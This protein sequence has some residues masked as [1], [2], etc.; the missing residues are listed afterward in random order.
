MGADGKHHKLIVYQNR[1]NIIFA[2]NKPNTRMPILGN[3]FKSANS[4]RETT[5]PRATSSEKTVREKKN[6]LPNISLA[7][8]RVVKITGLFF[9]IISLYFMVAF[10]SYLFTWQDDQSYVLASNGGWSNLF[11]TQKDFL[12]MGIK[13]PVVQNWLGKLGGLLAHQFIYEWFGIASF[14]FIAIFFI[15]GYRLLFKVKIW[16]IQKSLGYCFFLLIFIS[17]FIDVFDS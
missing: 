15:V 9:L 4:F 1:Y 14:I 17:V 6:I 13:Q 16:S 8:R 7:D 11:K 10:T 3:Q 12:E 5:K 2:Y